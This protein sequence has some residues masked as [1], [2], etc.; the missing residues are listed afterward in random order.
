[1]TWAEINLLVAVMLWVSPSYCDMWHTFYPNVLRCSK[2]LNSLSSKF[3]FHTYYT[4]LHIW[5]L[6][7]ATVID[8]WLY[9]ATYVTV[10]TLCISMLS[11]ELKTS[12][13][14]LCTYSLSIK[15][16][17]KTPCICFRL[18]FCAKNTWMQCY[19]FTSLTKQAQQ[20]WHLY[21]H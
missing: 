12:A 4:Y 6:Y 10:Y 11:N 16:G 18:I 8:L 2:A 5:H 21:M 13:K 19:S 1:M 15:V 20:Q 14:A 7:L 9:C 3:D 17:N